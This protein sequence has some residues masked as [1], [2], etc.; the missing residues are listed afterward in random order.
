M[1][2]RGLCIPK[3]MACVGE[4]GLGSPRTV[5]QKLRAARHSGRASRHSIMC[6][7]LSLLHPHPS[8]HDLFGSLGKR[9]LELHARWISFL[10]E[11]SSVGSESSVPMEAHICVH[12]MLGLGGRQW[13]QACQFTSHPRTRCTTQHTAHL[14]G[15]REESAHGDSP[16]VGIDDLPPL[17]MQAQRHHAGL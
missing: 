9:F 12:G 2:V 16:G 17:H 6:S 10:H 14:P 1:S 7:W 11:A 4:T 15:A 5:S 3:M 8:L 13:V